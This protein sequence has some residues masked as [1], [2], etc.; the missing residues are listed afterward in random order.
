MQT[1]MGQ[2][3]INEAQVH[4]VCKRIEENKATEEEICWLRDLALKGMRAAPLSHTATQDDELLREMV[5]MFNDCTYFNSP[6]EALIRRAK[7]H[8][9]RSTPAPSSLEVPTAHCW[10]CQR[11]KKEVPW[12]PD[13]NEVGLDEKHIGCGEKLE[14][15]KREKANVQSSTVAPMPGDPLTAE[16]EALFD[17]MRAEAQSLVNSNTARLAIFYR[18]RIK[19]AVSARG[20]K[21]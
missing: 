19:D 4:N 10:W 17:R 18:E 15:R 8:L 20:D 16:E 7:E 12:G 1:T 6:G 21:Q 14:L 2:P 3:E 9:A 13:D 5:K 11:C